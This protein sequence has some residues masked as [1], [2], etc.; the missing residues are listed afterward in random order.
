MAVDIKAEF[1]YILFEI[2][3]SV[4]N[5]FIVIFVG[6]EVRVQIHK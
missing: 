6:S 5:S 3:L 2:T 4:Q 1:N